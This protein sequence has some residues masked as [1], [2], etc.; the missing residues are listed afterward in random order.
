MNLICFEKRGEGDLGIIDKEEFPF[1][2]STRF[3]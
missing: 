1:A 3:G 2:K